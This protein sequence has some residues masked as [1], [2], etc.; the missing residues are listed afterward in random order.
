MPLRKAWAALVAGALALAMDVIYVLVLQSEGEGDLGRA[1]ARLIAASLA[2]AAAV[3]LGG[4]LVRDARVR[5]GLLSAAAFTMLAWG[6]LGMFTI[7]LPIFVAGL[8][9][10]V[11]A[12]RA[13]EEVPTITAFAITGLTG[14]AA[15]VLAGAILGTTS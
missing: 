6:F 7:G 3:S 11:P 8:L 13:A 9:L 15:L 14:A 4:W 2:A 1:R 10:L 12:S 5:L